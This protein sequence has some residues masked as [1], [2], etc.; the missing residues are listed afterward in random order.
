MEGQVEN[1]TLLAR[2]AELDRHHLTAMF[3]LLTMGQERSVRYNKSVI[4]RELR[5]IVETQI[6]AI[7]IIKWYAEQEGL[8]DILGALKK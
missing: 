4:L 3:T 6:D 5:Q 1:T 8:T 7:A 2:F